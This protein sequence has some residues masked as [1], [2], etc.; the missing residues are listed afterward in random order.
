LVKAFAGF[1]LTMGAKDL[2]A[3]MQADFL[4]DQWV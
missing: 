3:V 1:L 4:A 2:A